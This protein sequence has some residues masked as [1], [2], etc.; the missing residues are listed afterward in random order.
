MG[1]IQEKVDKKGL[2]SMWHVYAQ[3]RSGF[4]KAAEFQEGV[5][6]LGISLSEYEADDVI[7][8]INH[9]ARAAPRPSS[10]P[11]P[12]VP[13]SPR[14]PPA[15]T[16]ALASAARPSPRV[17]TPAPPLLSP[18]LSGTSPPSRRRPR[19]CRTCRA[20]SRPPPPPTSP[21]R[22]RRSSTAS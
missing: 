1:I 4:I 7:T 20:P 11:L 10:P 14:A 8:A 19:T 15:R 2:S 21:P 3:D 22:P 12:P 18:H 13:P 16:P 6:R 9:Q 17:A 5:K